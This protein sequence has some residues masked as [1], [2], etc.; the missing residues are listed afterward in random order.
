MTRTPGLRFGV[1]E[2]WRNAVCNRAT[3][4]VLTGLCALL[5]AGI[6]ILDALTVAQLTSDEAQWVA[7][8]GDVLVVTNAG[9]ISALSCER[10]NTAEGVRAAVGVVK[11]YDQRVGLGN[12]PDA[13]LPI[14]GATAGIGGFLPERPPLDTVVVSTRTAEDYGLQGQ[15][16]IDLSLTNTVSQ[17]TVTT[18]TDDGQTTTTDATFSGFSALQ[19]LPGVHKLFVT[20]V[21]ILGDEYSSGVLL[22]IAATG[23][24]DACLVWTQPGTRDIVRQSVVGI[25]PG[26]GDK[27]TVVADRLIT[28]QFSRDYLH[29]YLHRAWRW[30]PLPAGGL[31]GL[32]WIL[33]RWVKRSDDGLYQSLGVSRSTRALIRTTEWAVYAVA[34]SLVGL[35]IAVLTIELVVPTAPFMLPHLVRST[36]GCLF[37]SMV[38]AVFAGLLP[39]RNPLDALKDR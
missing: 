18:T 31:L 19:P 37:A 2:G 33:L 6:S 32:V 28:S 7:A 22:P 35:T 12:A 34:G 39:A 11:Q 27:P 25:L 4:L 16:W 21:S 36:I 8:G 30:A 9:G 23:W 17:D 10:L 38:V 1:G 5:F 29:D 3:G 13:N 20:D 26:P 24:V 15:S 14:V